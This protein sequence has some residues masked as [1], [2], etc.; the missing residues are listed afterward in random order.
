MSQTTLLFDPVDETTDDSNAAALAALTAA[1]DPCSA[2][3]QW[4]ATAKPEEV[5]SVWTDAD[6]L[7][8]TF[9]R[10]AGRR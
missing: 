7:L 6:S 2:I 4:L 8:Y 1:V 10:K 3:R 5:S 9:D